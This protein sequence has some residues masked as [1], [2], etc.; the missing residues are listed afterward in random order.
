[1]AKAESSFGRGWEKPCRLD[2]TVPFMPGK[3]WA[4]KSCT[5]NSVLAP[6]P[7]FLAV[8]V[9]QYLKPYF[10][11]L[12]VSTGPEEAVVIWLALQGHC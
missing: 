3:T 5:D 1:M 4:H 8:K 11:V 9:K 7:R 12:P 10:S 2:G 6:G